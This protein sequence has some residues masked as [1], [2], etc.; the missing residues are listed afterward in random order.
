[1][2][3]NCIVVSSIHGSPDYQ[4]FSGSMTIERL[5]RLL[6]VFCGIEI[7]EKTEAA[8]ICVYDVPVNFTVKELFQIST[9]FE[10]SGNYN[11]MLE[12]SIKDFS[13]S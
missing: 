7:T 8:G 9:I 1:M 6:E 2:D 11:Q 5:S 12:T 4:F 3:R 10:Y 13:S